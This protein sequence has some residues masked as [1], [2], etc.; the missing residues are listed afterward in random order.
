MKTVKLLLGLLILAGVFW[1]CWKIV[2]PY[3]ANY[4][5][6]DAITEEA[7]MNTYTNKSEEDMRQSIYKKAQDLDIPI[8]HDQISVQRAGNSVSISVDYTVH[9]ELPVHP[10]DL[11]FHATTKN[12]GI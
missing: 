11:S 4:Q 3:F 7:R 1:V 2:P 5:L 10:V 6:E 9:V 8:T 12:K